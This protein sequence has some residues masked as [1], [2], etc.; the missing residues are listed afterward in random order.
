MQREL[1][2]EGAFRETGTGQLRARE[3]MKQ[4]TSLQ[5]RA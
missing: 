3:N 2:K 4:Q 1:K 5:L